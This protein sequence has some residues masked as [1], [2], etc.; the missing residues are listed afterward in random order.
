MNVSHCLSSPG[1]GFNSQPRIVPW[2][3]A[4]CQPILS[5]RDRNWLNLPSMASRNHGHRGVRPKSNHGQTMALTTAPDLTVA[6]TST[7]T[8]NGNFDVLHFLQKGHC[9]T[10][11]QVAISF[12]LRPSSLEGVFLLLSQSLIY[13][14]P[15]F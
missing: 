2:S 4:L 15:Y 11:F 10:V 9:I 1:P 13:N 6:T 3:I 7:L 5:Q 8:L 12:E 14:V